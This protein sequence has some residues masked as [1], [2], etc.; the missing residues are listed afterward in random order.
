[1]I[2]II[3]SIIVIMIIIIIKYNSSN[4]QAG[5]VHADGRDPQGLGRVDPRRG[6]FHYYYC[7]V[8]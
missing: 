6:K 8:Y 3:I 4:R 5:E 7:Y 1:M 2:V